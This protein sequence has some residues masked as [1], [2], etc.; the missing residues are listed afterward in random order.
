MREACGFR[1]MDLPTELRWDIYNYLPE[2]AYEPVF[3]EPFICSWKVY[4]MPTSLLQVNKTIYQDAK[5]PSVQKQVQKVN[6]PFQPK[7]VL[8]PTHKQISPVYIALSR[9][10]YQAGKRLHTNLG[11]FQELGNEIENISLEL[12]SWYND[13]Y[14]H[15]VSFH[16]KQGSQQETQD[17]LDRE[18]E[19]SEVL[20]Y[21]PQHISGGHEE[22]FET[23]TECRPES[24]HRYSEYVAISHVWADG[25]GNAFENGLPMCQLRMLQT[26]FVHIAKDRP[27]MS[28]FNKRTT[29]TLF[30]MDTLCI[31][32]QY[33]P[34]GVP[35]FSDIKRKAIDKMSIVYSSSSHT[36][37]LDAEMRTIPMAANDATKL[38]YI[39]CCG[40]TTRSWT[41]QEGCLPPSTIYALSDGIFSH[42]AA[43]L[44][45]AQ[46]TIPVRCF[47]VADPGSV[48]RQIDSSIQ[49][50]IWTSVSLRSFSIWDPFKPEHPKLKDL[51]VRDRFARVWNELLDRVSSL[52][53]D[54]PAIFANLLGKDAD[55][56]GPL[57]TVSLDPP[58][59]LIQKYW[60]NPVAIFAT[61]YSI[62]TAIAPHGTKTPPYT[63]NTRL[64]L[65]I[66]AW[67]IMPLVVY[68]YQSVILQ[69]VAKR[70]FLEPLSYRGQPSW[71]FRFGERNLRHRIYAALV[72]HWHIM[73]FGPVLDGLFW[74]ILVRSGRMTFKGTF[75][76]RF[77]LLLTLLMVAQWYLSLGTE[78]PKV[79]L[80]RDA[81]R[82]YIFLMVVGF[83]RLVYDAC[84]NGPKWDV[85]LQYVEIF[86][87]FTWGQSTIPFAISMARLTESEADCYWGEFRTKLQ[88]KWNEIRQQWNQVL[89]RRGARGV[90]QARL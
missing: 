68:L 25:L 7:I 87:Q 19:M 63:G 71:P 38:A 42:K 26:Y 54:T 29:N 6:D 3:P 46:C 44:A 24:L 62:W 37:V 5:H 8:G 16:W 50:E 28:L 35:M 43:R 78:D 30:W 75:L 13:T 90:P 86:L 27:T 47:R 73:L 49:R 60:F 22:T 84:T 83:A 77:Q 32:V 2:I 56:L 80:G 55:D 57:L 70:R 12:A 48:A 40:W 81:Q 59:R 79:V 67:F 21:L 9:T 88:V 85:F 1:F 4:R 82:F 52:P 20:T 18:G 34:S 89:R 51:L 15:H 64:I 69:H 33:T 65:I 17:S 74:I 23:P 36:L 72:A 66:P 10:F 39:Q 41:L 31:P 58:E 61:H 53:A 76:S 14:L 45:M 11:G